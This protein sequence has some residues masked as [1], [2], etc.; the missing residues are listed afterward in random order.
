[1]TELGRMKIH[2]FT[3]EPEEMILRLLDALEPVLPDY[4]FR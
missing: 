1:M 4:C 2:K 3:T